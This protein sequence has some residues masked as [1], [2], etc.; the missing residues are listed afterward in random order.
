MN[1]FVTGCD[2]NTEWQLPWF[3]ENFR[4]YNP[5]LEIMVCDFGM[6]PN[7]RRSVDR[8]IFEVDS[9][10]GWYK[11]PATLI[12]ATKHADKVFW[13]DTDC[14]VT[15]DLSGIFEFIQ[16]NKLTIALDNP[17]TTRTNKSHYNTGVFG[18]ENV[19]PILSQWAA[20][21]SKGGTHQFGDQTILNNMINNPLAELQHFEQLPREYNTLRLDFQDKTAPAN[22]LICH[23]T[24][25]RG[26]E[27]IMSQMKDPLE[28]V[29]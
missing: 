29:R 22:P 24:G 19:P 9:A 25:S 28:Y 11:K 1:A 17:I 5:D 10:V 2:K 12:E 18:C 4:K 16:P 8:P 6:T 15:G 20:Q 14:Q 21:C 26:N 23:W 7:M 3:L 13:I 27:V